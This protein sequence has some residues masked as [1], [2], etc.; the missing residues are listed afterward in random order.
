MSVAEYDLTTPYEIEETDRGYTLVGLPDR[1]AANGV[2]DEFE[3]EYGSRS[4]VSRLLPLDVDIV[5]TSNLKPFSGVVQLGGDT[6]V[7][8]EGCSED[9]VEVTEEVLGE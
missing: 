3:E 4:Y 1:G 2:M 7:A 9:L 6:L 5:S 8:T